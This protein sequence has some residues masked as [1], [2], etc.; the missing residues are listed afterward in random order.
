[1]DAFKRLDRL[2]QRIKELKDGKVIDANHINVLLS[3]ARQ[4]EFDREWQHQKQLRKKKKPAGLNSGW[5]TKREIRLELLRATLAELEDNLVAELEK[6]QEA[7]Q[8]RA[9]QVFMNAY[10]AAEEEGKNAWAAASAALQRNGF[11][12][13][14]VLIRCAREMRDMEV[15]EMEELLIERFKATMTEEELE[16]Q[17]MR[18]EMER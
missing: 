17:R 4:S 10:C 6:E 13:E 7:K 16:Q 8:V 5:K 14:D 2:K 3:E 9:A 12:R 18:E 11:D 15:R 1:M